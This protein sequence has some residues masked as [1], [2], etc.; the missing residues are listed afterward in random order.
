MQ[1]LKLPNDLEAYESLRE[2][3]NWISDT[4][5]VAKR[6]ITTPKNVDWSLFSQQL[7]LSALVKTNKGEIKMQLLPQNAPISVANFVGLARGGFFNGKIF[8]RVVPNFVAQTGCPRGDGYGSLD[9]TITSELTPMHYNT[10]GV[11]GMASAGNHTECSQW[12]IT[13]SPM[14][15]LDTNYSIFAK[16]IEGM[17]I[18]QDLSVGDVIENVII[19]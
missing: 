8:H 6:K 18:A 10:E 4:I 15:H 13:H 19:N 3:I 7:P 17:A 2:T 9:F 11:V 5:A 12:F 14:P 1:S 16:V